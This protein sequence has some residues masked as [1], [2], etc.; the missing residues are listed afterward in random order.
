MKNLKTKGFT[1]IELL[2]VIA[3]IGIL[4]SV[5]L[6]SLNSA[7]DGGADANIQANLAGA[8]TSAELFYNTGSTYEGVCASPS[9][10]AQ[11]L[12]AVRTSISST[13]TVLN[14]DG[15]ASTGANAVCHDSATGWA[16]VV[17]LKGSTTA[18]PKNYCVDGTGASRLTG[19]TPAGA[20][21]LAANAVVCP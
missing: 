17:P 14:A 4:A 7:R 2:V 21:Q 11:L 5:V 1:L 12:G 10:A 8:R 3:I 9:V 13:A 19:G 16:A 15:T 6:A 18:A 20:L